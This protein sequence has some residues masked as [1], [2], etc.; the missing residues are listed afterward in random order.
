MRRPALYPVL[1]LALAPAAWCDELAGTV[2]SVDGYQVQIEVTDTARVRMGDLV[3]LSSEV[4]GVGE[5]AIDGEWRVV[6]VSRGLLVADLDGSASGRPQPGYSATIAATGR[7][8]APEPRFEAPPPARQAP[9]PVVT[10]SPP[11]PAATTPPVVPTPVP[12]P[13]PAPGV[14]L[15][16]IEL[17]DQPL[18]WPMENAIRGFLARSGVPVR[19]LPPQLPYPKTATPPPAQLLGE[20]RRLGQTGWLLYLGANVRIDGIK[21]PVILVECYGPDGFRHC[22]PTP[23]TASP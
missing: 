7:P 1:L 8:P 15:V 10:P 6:E 17:G 23:G 13:P 19:E 4:P 2:T 20:L 22:R 3:R 12:P 18:W 14:F 11:P 9:P 5:V 16:G 21:Q